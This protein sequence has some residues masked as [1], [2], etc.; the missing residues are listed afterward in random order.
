MVL[1]QDFLQREF[2]VKTGDMLWS[3]ARGIDIRE[4]QPAQVHIYLCH[5]PRKFSKG[6]VFAQNFQTMPLYVL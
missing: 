5:S 1:G 2:G 4:V 6:F 3:Y